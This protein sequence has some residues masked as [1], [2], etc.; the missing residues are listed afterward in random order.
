M[1]DKI[2]VVAD[3]TVPESVVQMADSAELEGLELG[4]IAVEP[5]RIAGVDNSIEGFVELVANCC[6]K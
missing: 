4:R 2:A 3:M 1:A 5:D 6:G